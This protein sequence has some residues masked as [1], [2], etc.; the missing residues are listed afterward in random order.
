LKRKPLRKPL[1]LLLTLIMLF[2]L[3]PTASLAA[4]EPMLPETP[5]GDEVALDESGGG[6]ETI[7]KA[8]PASEL[9][10]DEVTDL[11]VS[12]GTSWNLIKEWQLFAYSDKNNAEAQPI[13]TGGAETSFK[14]APGDYWIKGMPRAGTAPLGGI[15]ITVDADHTEFTLCG[16][17][18]KCGNTGW[19]EG[20]DY[21]KTVAVNNQDN[22]VTRE[23]ELGLMGKNATLLALENDTVK[24]TIIPSEEKKAEGYQDTTGRTNPL[25][26]FEAI[27]VTCQEPV[28]VT[29]TAPA[30]SEIL[31]GRQQGYYTYSYETPDSAASDESG[32]SASYKL[33]KDTTYFYRVSHPD[34]VTCWKFDKWTEGGTV[35]VS[36]A[37]LHLND[38]AF[39]K[40]TVIRDF[41][42][43]KSDV[44]SIYL[45]VNEKGYLALEQGGTYALN[46]SRSWQAIESI[47]NA[48]TALPDMHYAVI[49]PETGTTSDVVTIT[50]GAHNSSTATLTAAKAGTAI[51]LATYD[52]MSY[53]GALNAI[54]TDGVGDPRFSAI[55]PEN[56]G[57]FVVSV[58]SD[59]SSIA[60]NM[61]INEGRNDTKV[62]KAVGDAL[63]GELD[64]L[65]YVD[66]T[67]GASYT[68][69]P[70][71]G[72]TVSVLHPTLTED[73][74]TYSGGF[75]DTDVAVDGKTGAVTVSGL[76]A[77]RHI[78]KVTK[79]DVSTY[80]VVTAKP[81][82]YTM[83]RYKTDEPVT[84]DT[85]LKPG[86][87]ITIQY[88]GLFDPAG[89]LAGIY[90]FN[91]GVNLTSQKGDQFNGG[92]GL[93]GVYD[94]PSKS[95]FQ[96]VSV[97]VPLYI[98]SDTLELTGC[99]RQGGYGSPLGTH[100]ALDYSVGVNPNFSAPQHRTFMGA[101]PSITLKV[102]YDKDMPS[103]LIRP[104]DGDT[105]IED[106]TIVDL[107]DADG[108]AVHPTGGAFRALAGTYTFAL[109]ARGYL[110]YQ[111]SVTVT[112]DGENLF[113]I[114]LTGLGSAPWDGTTQTEPQKDGEG[115]YLIGTGA[116][117]AWYI[118]YLT[119]SGN[120]RT[121]NARLTADIEL[122]GYPFITGAIL[123]G[124]FDGAGHK[125]D[126]L[127]R[128][129]SYSGGVI[130]GGLFN[131]IAGNGTTDGVTANG[132]VKNV[133]V[134]G[135]IEV[136]ATVDGSVL[137][138]SSVQVGG[139]AGR[140]FWGNTNIQK[141]NPDRYSAITNCVSNIDITVN[142]VV[143]GS[144][145]EL[146]VGGIVANSRG[147]NVDAAN[148]NFGLALVED[149]VNNGNINVDISGSYGIPCT[150]GGVTGQTG[151]GT[152]MTNVAN[153]GTVSV[154]NSTPMTRV[155][156]VGGIVGYAHY[157]LS[158]TSADKTD[159]ATILEHMWNSGTVSAVYTGTGA[160]DS[161]NWMRIGGIAGNLY[162]S[163]NKSDKSF[164]DA[165][166]QGAVS[167]Q[168]ETGKGTPSVG[169]IIGWVR[170]N[171]GEPFVASDLYTTQGVVLD[172]TSNA[173]DG[174][175]YI[176]TFT[177]SYYQA[178]DDSSFGTKLNPAVLTLTPET[179]QE[180][181]KTGVK[182]Y[183]NA[184]KCIPEAALTQT[185][186]ADLVK[187][188]RLLGA[189]GDLQQAVKAVEDKIAAIGMVTLESK[190]KIEAA[191]AAY[192]ALPTAQADLVSNYQTL[193]VAEA[194][195]AQ[196]LKPVQD[197]EK[198]I[199]ELPEAISGSEADL[200]ALLKASAAF[201]KLTD[202]E[203]AQLTQE[204]KAKL[205]ALQE[206]AAKINHTSNGVQIGGLPWYIVLTAAPISGGED[207]ETMKKEAE[208]NLGAGRSILGMYDL[209]LQEL[210]EN[211]LVEYKLD[212]KTALITITVPDLAKYKNI[213]IIHQLADGS[214]EYITPSKIEGNK[215]SF[216][217]KSLS[218]YAVVG[219]LSEAEPRPTP[220]PGDK[221]GKPS[222]DGKQTGTGS[223]TGDNS[224]IPTIASFL[225]IAL[226]ACGYLYRRR[227]EENNL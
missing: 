83:Y 19:V 96:M 7:P 141:G 75:E 189:L 203:K 157:N 17:Q 92:G 77:G 62:E 16:S 201:D 32:L 120:D 209:T 198:L 24:V 99:L 57:V 213:K 184:L 42:S 134:N 10:G 217:V 44:G 167:A 226:C 214:Y 56:T 175:N 219:Q 178:E 55:W 174:S 176:Y 159:T 25:T 191:R 108:N 147:E 34:G 98:A 125:I 177:N 18:I 49:D 170:P 46:V 26:D 142:C 200:I 104:M 166:N 47:S 131:T 121:V 45:N 116:E 187:L 173:P 221:Q 94:F 23:I 151:L 129:E 30:G 154:R 133:T 206:E 31:V 196:L 52:A 223:A 93:Y 2:S 38:G 155:L 91:T 137:S 115:T 8:A 161:N 113:Q 225:L 85:V 35:A 67:G 153:H 61:T 124:T 114:P 139:I 117:L 146:R 168:W 70:E 204:L 171:S 102:E 50:P 220:S 181:D 54:E 60:A 97:T 132:A 84:A 202:Q 130:V 105:P 1:A 82:T 156:D 21:T 185:D 140:L 188:E 165:Y 119:D 27:I 79:G 90:N 163:A 135:T 160:S 66:G 172:G 205:A 145:S 9:L 143:T 150:V 127:Y 11:D 207:Y 53:P 210:T 148:S 107:K 183:Y 20:A 111:G 76:T 199:D 86:D 28:G 179:V 164:S 186:R 51:V 74:M 59:G 224:S 144:A 158:N 89:K 106:F 126:N 122:A 39:T 15:K 81:L 80:Q 4:G 195:L 211:G 58:G 169:G 14:L 68:F 6:Q 63:D 123:Y 208:N 40:S 103:C 182:N 194:A 216:E 227:K 69:T 136:N 109:Q 101:L 36:A 3:L 128:N 149:C 215:V 65:Y 212:G 29:F 48:E 152:Q 100:R 222:D 71:S 33:R 72:C 112:A 88:S 95:A 118:S 180:A 87:R 190:T 138:S 22:T 162:I 197:A 12:V 218:K 37:D 43:N 192:D 41:S 73:K 78:V 64:V 110:Y 193:T 5:M 13:K